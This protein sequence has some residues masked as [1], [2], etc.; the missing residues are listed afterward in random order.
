MT[1][2]NRNGFATLVVSLQSDEGL[3]ILDT[4]YI[5]DYNGV[6][7]QV[8]VYHISSAT[9]W[10]VV[11]SLVPTNLLK[12]QIALAGLPDG[13]YDVRG[14]VKDTFGNYSV[15]TAFAAPNGTEDVII[16]LFTILSGVIVGW[17][18]ANIR[19]YPRLSAN[20]RSYPRLS[21]NIRIY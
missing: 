6:D 1:I 11:M 17:V 8:T 9:S 10:P 5:E 3:G 7:A 13:D 14:R 2:F 20:I 18:T 19:S 21:A 12:G 16:I 4:D 15:I